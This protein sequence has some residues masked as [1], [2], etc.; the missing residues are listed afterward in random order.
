M[1]IA[2]FIGRVFGI[3]C[4]RV[5]VSVSLKDINDYNTDEIIVD[6]IAIPFKTALKLIDTD[7]N[8]NIFR[9]ETPS[10]WTKA[11]WRLICVIYTS[12]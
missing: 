12:S 4:A 7:T 3:S 1:T 8:S 9:T 10:S 11:A 6:Y 2:N 5:G